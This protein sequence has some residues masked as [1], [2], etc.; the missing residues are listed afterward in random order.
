MALLAS[1]FS[2]MKQNYT[3]KFHSMS[4]EVQQLMKLFLLF[5]F[6]SKVEKEAETDGQGSAASR[7]HT[8]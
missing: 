3:R 8:A 5:S 2:S 4:F 7:D 6:I 1:A